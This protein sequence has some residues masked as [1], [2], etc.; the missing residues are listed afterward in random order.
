MGCSGMRRP[1]SVLQASSLQARTV[2]QMA[3]G[4]PAKPGL[5]CALACSI[6]QTLKLGCCCA[7]QN[8]NSAYARTRGLA[9][10]CVA[11][12]LFGGITGAAACIRGR[13]LGRLRM[14]AMQE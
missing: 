6:A 1:R 7:M 14:C 2:L 13:S 10:R 3:A 9:K 12:T 4:R 11:G 5:V 8:A